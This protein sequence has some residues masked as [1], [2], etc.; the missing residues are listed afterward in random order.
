MGFCDPSPAASKALLVLYTWK[1]QRPQPHLCLLAV[2]ALLDSDG[3]ARG[4]LLRGRRVVQLVQ[5]CRGWV[6]TSGAAPPPTAHLVPAP[7]LPPA[8]AGPTAR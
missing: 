8:R 7:C 3:A 4:A 1:V 5:R 6:G 2:R